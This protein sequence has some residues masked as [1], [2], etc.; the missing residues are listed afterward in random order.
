VSS[1]ETVHHL[2][3]VLASVL[4]PVATAA[5]SA[6]ST[7]TPAAGTRTTASPGARAS[8]R[9]ASGASATHTVGDGRSNDHGACDQNGSERLQ[10]LC[11]S[12]FFDCLICKVAGRK[13]AA[14]IQFGHETTN[15]KL[16]IS[17]SLTA[18]SGSKKV[19]RLV[20]WVSLAV[21]KDA[22]MRAV[23]PKPIFCVVRDDGDRWC[24]EA[25]WPD[26]TIERI[27][28]FMAHLDATNWVTTLSHEWLRERT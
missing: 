5:A 25:E 20:L 12:V 19:H 21:I 2:E 15:R 3:A 17:Q 6:S 18:K 7:C 28:T 22:L 23:L 24:A 11:I 10:H 14:E 8:T 4:V 1:L 13:A 26:G 27:D 9:T 16:Q